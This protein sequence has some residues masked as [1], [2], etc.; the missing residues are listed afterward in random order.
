MRNFFL[1]QYKQMAER[2]NKM[3]FR[4]KIVTIQKNS[5]I[6]TLASDGNWLGVKVKD[7]DI[8]KQLNDMDYQFTITS[9]WGSDEMNEL[10]NLLGIGNTD[11]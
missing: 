1:E 10:V 11:I 6:L 9:E 5:D 4:E 8:Q 7:K 3:P 2:F